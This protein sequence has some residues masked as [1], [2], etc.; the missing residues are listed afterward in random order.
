MDRT[1]ASEAGNGSSNLPEG[2]QG[3][4]VLEQFYFVNTKMRYFFSIFITLF[5]S[6]FVSAETPFEKDLFFGMQNDP[7]VIRLQEFLKSEGYFAYPESTGN[8]LASTSE[9]VREF[10]KS[11]RI[12]PVGGF[13]GRES[14]E[15]A[16]RILLRQQQKRAPLPQL[17]KTPGS[18]PFARDLFLGI[19][20]DPDVARLQEFLR[21]EGHFTYPENTGNFF[22]LTRDAVIAFQNAHGISPAVGYFGHLTRTKANN[23]LAGNRTP[24]AVPSPSPETSQESKYKGK[25][26]LSSIRGKGV[27]PVD[28]IIVIT[29]RTKNESIDITGWKIKNIQNHTYIIPQADK[30]PGLG[31]S[32]IEN[33]VLSSGG[34]VTVSAGKQE[35]NMNFQENVC[36]GYLRETSVF[37]PDI[38]NSC[39]RIETSTLTQFD[40]ACI[41]KLRAIGACKTPAASN[42]FNISDECSRYMS[43][44][45]NYAGC[46]KN[47]R[48]DKNFYI[49]HWRI[50][51]QRETEFFRNTIDTAT[52]LDQ[53]GKVVDKKSY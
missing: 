28:E 34:K 51:M 5:F 42:L 18:A 10:Q 4:I 53:F 9:A 33:L 48:E 23:I 13:F 27:K 36:I 25:I 49:N 43:E 29:N 7:D 31:V 15:A 6:F 40:D 50:W 44:N 2:M 47:H 30:L 24:L 21:S 16:N 1:S 22:S 39:P 11:N 17:S 35:K 8:Y 41:Q 32:Y 52:L 46:V 19:K 37:K 12:E 45:F 14:R 3:S 26:V 20:D 38:S